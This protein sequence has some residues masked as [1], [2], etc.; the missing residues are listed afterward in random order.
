MKRARPSQDSTTPRVSSDDA[1]S[2]T[3]TSQSVAR[4]RETEGSSRRRS[5]AEFQ[6][7]TIS[8]S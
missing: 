2:T 8:E 7:T 5:P 1:L 3:T 4:W 6:V